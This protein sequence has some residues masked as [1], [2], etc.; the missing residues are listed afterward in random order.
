MLN[1]FLGTKSLI[2][3]ARSLQIQDLFHGLLNKF[4]MAIIHLIFNYLTI[5]FFHYVS[6]ILK[7]RESLI[8]WSRS[9]FVRF[10]QC[11]NVSGVSLQ[12]SIKKGKPQEVCSVCFL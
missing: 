11:C 2:I 10:K 7:K 12:K 9:P 4:E 5:F 3:I 1:R 8:K 6:V